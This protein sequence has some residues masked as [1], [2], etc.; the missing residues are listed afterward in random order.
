MTLELSSLGFPSWLCITHYIN[1]LFLTLLVRSGI[2]ILADHPRLYFN[3]HCTPGTEWIKFTKKKVP[4]ERFYTSHDDEVHVSP[5]I[6]LPGGKHRLG[7]G[8]Y[9]HFFCAFFWM[10]NGFVYVAFLF[11]TE[12]W[13]RLIP[14]AW[15][16]FGQA[17]R[18]IITYATFH[19]PKTLPLLPY[20][21][22]QQLTYFF[23]V[24]ILAPLA[25]LT[26][27][28]MSPAISARFPWYL[29]LFGGRQIARSIHF[30]A[31]VSFLIFLVIHIAMVAVVHFPL[32]MEH[33]VLGVENQK[34][35]LAISLGMVGIV[36][37]IAVHYFVT[38]WSNKKPRQVQITMGYLTN[39]LNKTL[40]YRLKSK[41]N[42]PASQRSP[43]FWVN[44]YPPQTRKWLKL[45]QSHFVDYEL[46]VYGLVKKPLKLSLKALKRMRYTE[47]TTKHCCIQGWTGIASWGGVALS[48][49]IK[50]CQPHQNARFI[51]FH[52]FQLDEKGVEYYSSLDVKEALYP[53]TILAYQM[54]GKDLPIE[55]G[56]PLRLRIE[57]KLGF[58]MTKWLKSIEFVEDLSSVGLGQGGYREDRQYFDSGAQI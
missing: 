31:M 8:R 54:N 6:A 56:A 4:K 58:K 14:T 42:Y 39:A 34:A 23:V 3:D 43:Y 37:V 55:Y 41:Q 7:L 49:I 30:L 21:A 53:Q 20:D 48:E 11:A 32:N 13:R 12:N 16:V 44:G 29:K 25:I 28:A 18:D 15:G 2:Q 57:T 46:E 19:I 10:L 1:L 35:A 26:G 9:W 22:L 51:V 17:G 45:A 27:T 47:Q 38:L 52:S 33:I 50:R 40:L 24:F 36:V 5:W